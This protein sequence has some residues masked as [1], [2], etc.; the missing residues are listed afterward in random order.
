MTWIAD[1]NKQKSNT[2]DIKTQIKF[3]EWI[4]QVK[5]GTHTAAIYFAYDLMD[6]NVVYQCK[7]KMCA[8][9]LRPRMFFFRFSACEFGWQQFISIEN[10]T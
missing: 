9:K 6:Q 3:H 2:K 10:S 7:H 8:D 4:P 1:C 5:C